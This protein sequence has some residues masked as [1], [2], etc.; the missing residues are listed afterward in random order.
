[1][2]SDNEG[3]YSF[4]QRR[5]SQLCE[6]FVKFYLPDEETC[7]SEAMTNVY[8]RLVSMVAL[9]ACKMDKTSTSKQRLDS[10]DSSKMK[11]AKLLASSLYQKR[12]ATN[13]DVFLAKVS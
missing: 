10:N 11:I 12:K 13:T 4:N 3:C 8:G 7:L 2:G 9:F 1:M 5:C 6:D